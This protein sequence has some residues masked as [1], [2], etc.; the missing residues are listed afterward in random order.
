MAH[1]FYQDSCIVIRCCKQCIIP[2]QIFGGYTPVKIIAVLNKAMETVDCIQVEKALF[3]SC[4][5]MAVL[6][7]TACNCG[8]AAIAFK[9]VAENQGTLGD[10]IRKKSRQFFRI[11]FC[12]VDRG[13][14]GI[15]LALDTGT[16]T[17]IFVGNATLPRL[18]AMFTGFAS[19]SLRK[20]FT[21]ITFKDKSLVQFRH[22]VKQ[23]M[24][25]FRKFL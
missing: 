3:F 14:I 15:P 16:D 7:R 17:D 1:P 18:G 12:P 8:E 10:M 13:S 24:F 20:G 21:L 11:R 2:V 23:D 6:Y 22:S 9:P 4:E 25:C 19:Y 5:I